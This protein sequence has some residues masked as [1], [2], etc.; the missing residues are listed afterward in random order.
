MIPLLSL[1]GSLG[2]SFGGLFGSE[3]KTKARAGW[4][5]SQAGE[6]VQAIAAV[7][8]EEVAAGDY[9]EARRYAEALHTGW[10]T[11]GG[12]NGEMTNPTGNRELPAEAWSRLGL[13]EIGLGS[14]GNSWSLGYAPQSEIEEV[15]A[16]ALRFI[17]LAE[18]AAAASA[19]AAPIP[20]SAPG[21]TAP[22]TRD[23]PTVSTGPANLSFTDPAPPPTSPPVPPTPGG[24]GEGT[25]S[26]VAPEPMADAAEVAEEVAAG[27]REAVEPRTIG[28]E[29]A[30]GL[31]IAVAGGVL[32]WIARR[33]F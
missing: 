16:D 27:A 22:V 2:G 4:Y 29:L 26:P 14:L 11:P 3:S 30:L 33:V 5:A 10:Q 21:T 1:G 24:A 23:R 31:G 19:S 15:R 13:S 17:Q 8:K 25:R 32:Y 18:E 6:V 20:T 7:I 12:V 9:V 28:R